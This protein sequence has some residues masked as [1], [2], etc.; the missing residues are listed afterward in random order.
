MVLN[1]YSLLAFMPSHNESI[2][3]SSNSHM[4]VS[5]WPI[6]DKNFNASLV[7]HSLW[8]KL[9]I[10]SW[11]RPSSSELRPF[12]G[13]YY[14]L[15]FYESNPPWR[16]IIQPQS[17]FQMAATLANIQQQFQPHVRLP[18]SNIPVKML[19]DFLPIKAMKDKN[20]YFY[21]KLVSFQ[22]ISIV[23]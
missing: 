13:G 17:S 12:D 3:H 5:R 18:T 21:F 8:R 23:I 7:G 9:A 2:E 20:S 22:V 19:T 6:K 4:E 1:D 11:R 10:I 14:Q 16:Q 15:N